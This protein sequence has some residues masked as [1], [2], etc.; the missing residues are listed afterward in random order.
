MEQ[1]ARRLK[2]DR[3]FSMVV[4]AY[5]EITP[6]SVLGAIDACVQKG[7]NEIL[8]LPYFLSMGNHVKTDIPRLL[9]LARKKYRREAKIALCPYLGYHEKIMAVVKERLKEAR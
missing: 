5:L 2:E 1:L 3:R 6:P 8:V 4:C 9:A 7:S